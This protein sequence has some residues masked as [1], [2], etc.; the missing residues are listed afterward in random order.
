VTNDLNTS[1]Q[2]TNINYH[3]PGIESLIY[4]IRNT[5]ARNVIVAGVGWSGTLTGMVNG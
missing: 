2:R 1:G 5:G 4:T 3:T